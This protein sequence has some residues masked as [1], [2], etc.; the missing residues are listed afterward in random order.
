MKLFKKKLAHSTRTSHKFNF[1]VHAGTASGFATPAQGLPDGAQAVLQIARGPKVVSTAPV[2]IAMGKA[3]W[4]APLEFVCTLYS[5]KKETKAFSEKTF[6][7]SLLLLAERRRAAEIAATDIDVA[8]FSSADQG[9]AER[10]VNY[11]FELKPFKAGK[12]SK[13]GCALASDDAS[14]ELTSSVASIYLK[15]LDV[16]P[17]EESISSVLPV[18]R[19]SALP[20]D[21]SS[22]ALGRRTTS[23]HL[24]Q[25]LRGFDLRGG[26]PF[27]D[28]AESD[29]G[30]EGP[31]AA[32]SSGGAPAQPPSGLPPTP[33]PP[34]HG[35]PPSDVAPSSDGSPAK[36]GLARQFQ[37]QAQALSS[38]TAQLGQLREELEEAKQHAAV[39]AA[40]PALVLQRSPPPPLHSASMGRSAGGTSLSLSLLRIPSA[41]VSPLRRWDLSLPLTPSH[42]FC[43]LLT[44]SAP[45]SRSARG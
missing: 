21:A 41:P 2:A 4:D 43:A 13:T 1:I 6:R 25:D 34:P 38:A 39:A 40:A 32:A 37:A 11:T 36:D 8:E 15:D 18:N 19:A 45:S 42:L 31:S 23:H 29:A 27:D 12:A 20:D 7:I 3:T 44:P 17:D 22:D 26:N 28:D 30:S 35:A 10:R 24:E 5:S 14:V 33:A 16:D 9:L